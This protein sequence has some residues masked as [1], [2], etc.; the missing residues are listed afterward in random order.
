MPSSYPQ[1][2][3]SFFPTVLSSVAVVANFW[4]F[5]DRPA[6]LCLQVEVG[7]GGSTSLVHQ[8]SEL[9]IT[10]SSFWDE[11]DDDMQFAPAQAAAVMAVIAAVAGGVATVQLAS[12]SCFALPPIKLLFIAIAEMVCAVFTLGSI[13]VAAGVDPCKDQPSGNC[14][15]N[16]LAG[17]RLEEGSVAAI[18]ACF[19][20]GWA[21]LTVLRYRG[22]VNRAMA[23]QRGTF[24]APTA[25]PTR[26]SSSPEKHVVVPMIHH[27]SN[28]YNNNHNNHMN[29]DDDDDM[30]DYNDYDGDSVGDEDEY[31]D[32]YTAEVEMPAA[33]MVATAESS[34][35]SG[36]YG[37]A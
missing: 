31:S 22:D 13:F 8:C 30:N 9:M 18:F 11:E 37:Q 17:M 12:A 6:F 34:E 25:P 23:A 27:Q 28:N 21:A 4:M 7:S 24:P 16:R 29:D 35:P 20:Y 14:E 15:R 2:I 19:F 5:W 26:N 1:G 3:A 36:I 10:D 32:I 33:R